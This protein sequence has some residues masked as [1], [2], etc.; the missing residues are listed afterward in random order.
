MDFWTPWCKPCIIDILES[1]DIIKQDYQ[2]KEIQFVYLC[3]GPNE[4]A[5]NEVMKE[6]NIAGIHLVLEGEDSRRSMSRFNN[7][8]IPFQIIVDKEGEVVRKGNDIRLSSPIT[9]SLINELLK[10]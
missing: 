1:K 7:S 9:K 8:A 6:N 3:T 10:N 4:D 5:C 2:S